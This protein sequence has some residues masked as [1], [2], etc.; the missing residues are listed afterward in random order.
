M[1]HQIGAACCELLFSELSNLIFLMVDDKMGLEK[2]HRLTLKEGLKPYIRS[3][4][5]YRN[6]FTAKLRLLK[7]LCENVMPHKSQIKLSA[8]THFSP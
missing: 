1:K 5:S 4:I 2:S 6:I 8:L 3:R 7:I